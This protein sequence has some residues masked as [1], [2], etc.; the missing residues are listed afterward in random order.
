MECLT[1]LPSSSTHAHHQPPTIHPG[2]AACDPELLLSVVPYLQA[3][4]KLGGELSLVREAG[5]ALAKDPG[6]DL[7]EW[8]TYRGGWAGGRGMDGSWVVAGG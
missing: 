4:V 2:I 1:Q 5:R 6:V 3:H 8:M 7:A